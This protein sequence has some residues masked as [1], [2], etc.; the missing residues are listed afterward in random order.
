MTANMLR[1]DFTNAFGEPG[2]EADVT[3]SKSGVLITQITPGAKVTSLR[4]FI[5]QAG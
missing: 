4:I 2:N 5:I 1:K 3:G